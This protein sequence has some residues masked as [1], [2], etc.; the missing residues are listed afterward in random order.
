MICHVLLLGITG[1]GK[2]ALINYL[3]GEEIA[4]SGISSRAGGITHG[5]NRY[6]I[7]INNQACNVF[8]SEGLEVSHADY[9]KKMISNELLKSSATDNLS[10]WYHIVVYCIGANSGRIQPFEL[11]IIK[12]LINDGYGVIIAFTKADVVTNEELEAL[13]NTIASYFSD[14]SQLTYIPVC[15]VKTRNNILEG[16]ELLADAIWNAW[17]QSLLYRLPNY[18]YPES[19]FREIVDFRNELVDYVN[20]YKIGFFGKSIDDLITELNKFIEEGIEYWNDTISDKQQKAENDMKSIYQMLGKI[21]NLKSLKIK[22]KNLQCHHLSIDK[23]LS[24]HSTARKVTKTA[25]LGAAML[26]NP[27]IGIP[28]AFAAILKSR[29]K[30]NQSKEQI[31]AAITEQANKLLSFYSKQKQKFRERLL[32]Y[33]NHS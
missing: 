21:S 6:S 24:N 7:K 27:I 18:V 17:G 9:W 5:I 32:D 11:E 14:N 22:N 3:A 26:I 25:A 2:S 15:S 12:K 33:A 29:R 20:E 23:S 16:K 10:K 31:T 19:L 1:V 28:L 4:Q 30:D 8:D 13:Q